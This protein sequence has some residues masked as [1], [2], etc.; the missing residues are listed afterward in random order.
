MIYDSMVGD[1]VHRT[2]VLGIISAMTHLGICL[3]RFAS[4]GYARILHASAER[5]E[6]QLWVTR[7]DPHTGI[8]EAHVK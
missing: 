2:D 4:A 7:T 6:A 5:Y 1:G 8:F 3:I